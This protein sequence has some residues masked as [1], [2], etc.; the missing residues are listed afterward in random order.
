MS[1]LYIN[2]IAIPPGFPDGEGPLDDRIVVQTQSD[3]FNSNIWTNSV[4]DFPIDENG[5]PVFASNAKR[6]VYTGMRVSVVN[7]GDNNGLYL[8]KRKSYYKKQSWDPTASNYNALGWM[9]INNQADGGGSGDSII[10][11][12]AINND[13]VLPGSFALAVDPNDGVEKYYVSTI[14]GGEF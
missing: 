5:D 9:K 3:L 7:D 8:L 10:L 12:T 4:S 14:N 13:T 6:M 2:T 1:F 11:D